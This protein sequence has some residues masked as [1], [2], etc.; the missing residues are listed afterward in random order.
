[1]WSSGHAG[2]IAITETGIGGD[3]PAIIS[4]NFGE[5]SLSFSD[6]T[7]QHNGAA[8]DPATGSL[9]TSGSAV[10]GLPEY[11]LGGN[12]IRFANNARD[13]NPYSAVVEADAPTSW[14][15]LVDN[16][17]D[18][19]SGNTSSPNSTDPVLAGTLQWI[20]DDGWQRVNTGISPNGQA[21]YT[22]VDEGG[23][24]VGAGFGL[25]QF[26]SVY[27]LEGVSITI[28]GQ[29]IGGSNMLSLVAGSSLD[30]DVPI[31]SFN[32][33]PV[34]SSGDSAELRWAIHPD[35]TLATISPGPGSVLP[36][37]DENGSGS[38]PVTP[39]V[40]TTYTLTVESPG[41]GLRPRMHELKSALLRA[42][43]SVRIPLSAV[44]SR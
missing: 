22:G 4:S 20:V 9:S 11:L 41:G 14:Y 16:R 17:L 34:V 25:N 36:A 7:H 33:P 6:R 12:Y 5:E 24:A 15:L 26:Y 29:G 10:I 18:G 13:N 2:I 8:F 40:S 32:A 27:T 43:N 42:S 3:A 23:N 1:M 39:L 37:T 19:L 21:D 44:V 35:A 38:L 28:R 30:N 31:R